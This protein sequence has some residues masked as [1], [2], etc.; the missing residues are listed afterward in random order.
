MVATGSSTKMENHFA[1]IDIY[2]AI[3]DKEYTIDDETLY[4]LPTN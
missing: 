1:N 4:K 2:V 3:E